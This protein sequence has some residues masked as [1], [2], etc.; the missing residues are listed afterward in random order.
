MDKINAIRQAQ[1]QFI[2][3]GSLNRNINVTKFAENIDV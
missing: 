2:Q 3:I 1:Q